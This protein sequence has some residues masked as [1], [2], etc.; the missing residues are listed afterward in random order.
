MNVNEKVNLKL[1]GKNKDDLKVISAY[2]Q[3]SVLKVKDIV[4]LKKNKTFIMIV[5]RFMWEDF[6]KGFFRKNKRIRCAV[7]FEEVIKVESKNINQKNKNKPLEFL[8]IRWNLTNEKIFKIKIFFSGD[9]IIT[10]TT[11]SID[12]IMHDLGKPWEVKRVPAHK[13]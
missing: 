6:E 1:M 9:A 10:I 5:N 12:V 2:L 8:A 7:K 4:F 3:D 11:E 13:L